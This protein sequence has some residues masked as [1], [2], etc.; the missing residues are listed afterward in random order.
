MIHV[1]VRT[2]L[3]ERQHHL[4]AHA[5]KMLDDLADGFVRVDLIQG[6]IHVVEKADLLDP[7]HVSRV[8]DL[9]FP[10]SA[11]GFRTRILGAVMITAP[12]SPRRG[13]YVC[14]HSLRTVFGQGAS[15]PQ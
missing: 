7:E 13:Y 6:P 11:H 15:G 4:R 9:L 2:R 1:A 14:L 12:L 10:D 8:H 5:A 3:I